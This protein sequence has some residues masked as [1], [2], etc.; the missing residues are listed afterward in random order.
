MDYSLWRIL[1]DEAGVA[2][3]IIIAFSVMA[4][5]V[6]IERLVVQWRFTERARMLADTVARCLNRGALDEGRSA[7]ERSRSPLADIFLVGYARLGRS[8]RE[9]LHNAVHRER[10]RVAQDLKKRLWILGTIGATAPFI[11]LFGTVVGIMGAFAEIHS[12]GGQGGLDIVAGPISEALWATAAG[13]A[14]G[15]EAVIIYNYF[16]QRLGRIAVELKM[17]TD[18]FLELLEEHGPE[19]ERNAEPVPEIPPKKKE[20]GDGDREAA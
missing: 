11:G 7:C 1:V 14:V 20:V 17:L 8:S 13:I 5:A 10:L 3:Y 6:A 12:A 9:H 4:V 15:I 18:E 19:K 2:I 16:N